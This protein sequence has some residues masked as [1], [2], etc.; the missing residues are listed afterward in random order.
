[1]TKID[2][3]KEEK[4][5]EIC[6]DFISSTRI[7]SKIKYNLNIND[8]EVN[9]LGDLENDLIN[10][11]NKAVTKIFSEVDSENLNFIFVI[12]RIYN[13][14]EYTYSEILDMVSLLED[15]TKIPIRNIVKIMEFQKEYKLPVQTC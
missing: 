2:K 1:M 11:R 10:I 8:K 13:G 4:I 3:T 15:G 12:L 9:S 5:I 6:N 14:V 7:L